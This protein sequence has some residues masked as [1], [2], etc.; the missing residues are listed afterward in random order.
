M[1]AITD[2]L[3]PTGC[4]EAIS[5]EMAGTMMNFLAFGGTLISYGLLSDAP[6]GNINNMILMGKNL[7]LEGYLLSHDPIFKSS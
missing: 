7:K 4:L 6:V 5:G 1:T 2:K 3:K